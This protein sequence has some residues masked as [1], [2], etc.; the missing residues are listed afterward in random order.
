MRARQRIKHGANRVRVSASLGQLMLDM[1][2][3]LSK[4]LF[5]RMDVSTKLKKRKQFG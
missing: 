3:Q 5:V 1:V 4:V 2:G